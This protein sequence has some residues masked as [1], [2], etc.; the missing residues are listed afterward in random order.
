MTPDDEAS[1]EL[2]RQL[3]LAGQLQH[4]WM[5]Q[6]SRLLQVHPAAAML[7]ADLGTLGECRLSDLAK[8]RMV[9]ISVVSRQVSQL[10]S[11]GLVDRR[12]APK[13]GRAALVRLS[14]RGHAELK[15]LRESY[16]DLVRAALSDWAE[17]DIVSLAKSI[18]SMNDALRNQMKTAGVPVPAAAGATL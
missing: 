10:T 4:A 2:L 15:R 5:N 18:G 7:L 17:G 3:R 13:D 12:P 1:L 9:D 16:L 6:A 11:A 8:R 14:E